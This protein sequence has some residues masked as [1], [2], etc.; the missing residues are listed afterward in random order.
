VLVLTRKNH[1]VIQI[2]DNITIAVLGTTGNSVRLGVNAPPE[3][4]VLREELFLRRQQAVPNRLL[5]VEDCPEDRVAYR[6]FLSERGAVPWVFSEADSGEA[7]LA[8]C[9]AQRPDCVLL[10]YLLPDLDGIEFL[11]RLRRQQDRRDIP[12]IMVTGNAA[13]DLASQALQCGAKQLLR[14]TDLSRD[15]LQQAVREAL[16][17]ARAN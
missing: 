4:E 12:V 17:G 8:L 11:D 16:R 6:R 5:I 9:A 15:L 10:D 14:K 2:G 3:V 1:E 7:G 13:P